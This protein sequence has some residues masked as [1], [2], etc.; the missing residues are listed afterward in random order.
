V[1]SEMCIRD[2]DE[3]EKL[4]T[5]KEK[6]ENAE[7]E[8]GLDITIAEEIRLLDEALPPIVTAFEESIETR[9]NAILAALNS[10]D[11]SAIK[12][13]TENPRKKIRNLATNQLRASR[14]FIRATDE[15]NKQKLIDERNEL[16]ARQNLSKTLESVLDLLQRMKDR[17]ALEA[18]RKDLKTR[19]ISDKS[20]EFASKAVTKELKNALDAEF[21]SLGVGHIK[22]KLKERN[23]RGKML[24][25]NCSWTFRQITL[26]TKSS[27]RVSS[28]QLPSVHFWRNWRLRI[29]LAV[30]SLMTPFP[31]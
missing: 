23:E 16:L 14:T 6:T 31:P 4:K 15:E 8:I 21:K 20:K 26:L 30:L 7:L 19:S 1:G 11:W 17:V 3:R 18:C 2:R 24:H 10:H 29:I 28:G 22:T 13:L 25:T 5:A 12:E 9:R 27:V